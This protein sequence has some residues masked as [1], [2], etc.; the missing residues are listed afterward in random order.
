MN[1]NFVFYFYFIIFMQFHIYEN[2]CDEIIF[3]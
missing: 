1:E 2:D 3:C